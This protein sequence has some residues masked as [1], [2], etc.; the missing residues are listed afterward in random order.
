MNLS[1]IHSYHFLNIPYGS[2]RLCDKTFDIN[3]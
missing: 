1:F 2:Y 3:R